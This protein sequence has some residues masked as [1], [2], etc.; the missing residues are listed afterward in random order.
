MISIIIFLDIGIKYI[1]Q[2]CM[3]KLNKNIE[4]KYLC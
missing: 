1:E 4:I 2:N 3:G